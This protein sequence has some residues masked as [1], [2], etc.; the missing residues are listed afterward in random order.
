[1]YQNATIQI[2]LAVQF[3]GAQAR[4]Q[5]FYGNKSQRPWSNFE[6]SFDRA[7]ELKWQIQDVNSTVAVKQQVKQKVLLICM[8]PLSA[9]PRF[10]VSFKCGNEK[11]VYKLMFPVTVA[12]FT[13][14]KTM[15]ADVFGQRWKSMSSIPI[16]NQTFDSNGKSISDIME[17]VTADNRLGLKQAQGIDKS[18]N[19]LSCAGIF[20][21]KTKGRRGSSA[22]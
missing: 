4:L 7:S 22:L 3:R 5:I 20:E 14:G 16:V 21:T 18:P 10:T 15:T 17:R 11:H 9:S 2:G 8:K 1:M 13:T 6:V 19:T 12:S